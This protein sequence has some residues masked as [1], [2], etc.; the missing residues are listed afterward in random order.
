SEKLNAA[1]RAVLLQLQDVKDNAWNL[2][3]SSVI[4][5]WIGILPGVGATTASIVSYSVAKTASK[6]ADQF[7]HG[8]SEGVVAS[9]SANNAAALG[10][11]VPLITLGIPGSVITAILLGAMVIHELNPGP[12]LFTQRPEIAYTVIAA[13][14]AANIIVLLIMWVATPFLARLMYIN[15]AVILPMIVVFCIVGAYS[16]TNSFVDVSVMLG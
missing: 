13:G 6:N 8:A 9:E 12:L 16:V 14:L 5:T 3:R 11:L 2:V 1:G 15:K 10:S 4:G 7:G